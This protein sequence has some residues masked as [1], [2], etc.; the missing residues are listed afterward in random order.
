MKKSVELGDMENPVNTSVN[1]SMELLVIQRRELLL[2]Y[3][4]QR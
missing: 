3:L 2:Q 1:A 4:L